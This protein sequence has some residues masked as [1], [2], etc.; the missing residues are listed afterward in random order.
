MA[1]ILL[2]QTPFSPLAGWFGVAS[3]VGA[4]LFLAWRLIRQRL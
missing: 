2:W 4:W 3:G 1:A